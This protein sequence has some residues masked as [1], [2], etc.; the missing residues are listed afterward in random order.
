MLAPVIDRQSWLLQAAATVTGGVSTAQAQTSGGLASIA[1]SML[2]SAFGGDPLAAAVARA[3]ANSRE[4]MAG[5][6]PVRGGRA[7]SP[8]KRGGDGAAPPA[9]AGADGSV[10]DKGGGGRWTSAFKGSGGLG[11]TSMPLAGG[12]GGS[13]TLPGAPGGGGGGGGGGVQRSDIRAAALVAAHLGGG[14]GGGA[15]GGSPQQSFAN[16]KALERLKASAGAGPR[17]Q[18]AGVRPSAGVT[19]GG[20]ASSA[21][22]APPP[23]ADGSAA[24]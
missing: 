3:R 6:S 10:T 24:P 23:A 8:P 19:P 22:I 12:S 11:S 13:V 2:R 14:G 17:G 5:V 4:K 7:P 16:W 15:A 21:G 1:G 20:G 18:A 9:A